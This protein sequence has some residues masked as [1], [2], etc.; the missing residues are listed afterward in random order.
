LNFI[1]LLFNIN[2][3]DSPASFIIVI[4]LEICVVA[5]EAFIIKKTMEYSWKK[6]FA[7][8]L[9]FNGCSFLFG[10]VFYKFIF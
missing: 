10:L 3:F 8:S 6:A 7:L 4:V 2:V 9:F 1:L 5:A